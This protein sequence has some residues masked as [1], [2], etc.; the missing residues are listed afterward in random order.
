MIQGYLNMIVALS[1]TLTFVPNR[2]VRLE[3]KVS[4]TVAKIS[5]LCFDHFFWESVTAT[6]PW[7]AET[8][9]RK[10]VYLFAALV[11]TKEAIA[12]WFVRRSRL[13][14]FVYHC[15]KVLTN[16]ARHSSVSFRNW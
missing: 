13:G 11:G 15:G 6:A 9:I 14:W 4:L 5:D 12:I 8:Y 3:T 7:F 16:L 10:S 1:P 2:S